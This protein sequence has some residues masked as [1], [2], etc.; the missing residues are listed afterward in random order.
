MDNKTEKINIWNQSANE[1]NISSEFNLARKPTKPRWGIRHAVY[2]FIISLL[3]QLAV[4]IP[5]LIVDVTNRI[6]NG[7]LNPDTYEDELTQILLQGPGLFLAQVSMY[8]GWIITMVYVTYRLGLRSFAKDFWVRFKWVRDIVYGIL[9]GVS[10]RLLEILAFALMGQV[11]IDLTGADN[12]SAFMN[13]ENAVWLYILLFGLVSFLGPLCEEL[14]FRGLLL[15]GLIRTFRRRTFLPR[16]WFGVAV[17]RTYPPLFNGFVKFK[18]FL[19]RHK[20]ALAAVISAA[21]FGFM[22]FQGTETFG[23]WL[24]VIETGLIGLV[25]AIVA[26]KT[27]RLGLVIVAHMV[28]NFSAVALQLWL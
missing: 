19:Y 26:L 17:E 3:L 10:L 12:S 9:L 15:Q 14:F 13:Q 20:Y 22:H 23:Q 6:E 1:E 2:G 27:R 28:F 11:G 21:A 5:L 8:T 7:T 25:F 24:V 18:E 16:T 4:T